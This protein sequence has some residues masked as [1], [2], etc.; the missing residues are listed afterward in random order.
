MR[1]SIP[2]QIAANHRLSLVYAS[3]VVAILTAL[4]IAV[5][6]YYASE[7]WWAGGIGAFV[8]GMIVGLVAWHKGPDII[9]QISETRDASPAELR[10]LNNV[11]EEM[12]LAAGIPTPH[13]YLIDDPSPNAFATG[14]SPRHGVVVVTTG[15]MERLDRDELQGVVAHE[16]AHIRNNDVKLMT[17]LAIVAGLVP[18]ISEFFLRTFWRSGSKKNADSMLFLVLAL[19][20]AILAPICTKL[21]ELSVSRRREFLADATASQL[22]RN[23]D[24][25]AS[26]LEKISMVPARLEVANHATEH[27]FF[28]NPFKPLSDSGMA[29]FSTHPPIRQ[30]IAALR[31]T[32]GVRRRPIPGA[33][34]D[35]PEIPDQRR[36]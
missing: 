32:A 24:A 30:R 16:I 34:S 10:T 23:P 31:G 26:A 19:V 29:L 1:R 15:L 20:L 28:V 36:R 21:L 17:T 9:L 22:T 4:G 7:Y 8:L 2:E 25:L 33:F 18:L 3:M 11:T 27:M 14:K 5:T 6:G 13:V 35:M 12:A